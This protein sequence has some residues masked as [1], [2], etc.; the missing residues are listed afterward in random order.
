MPCQFFLSYFYWFITLILFSSLLFLG[1]G[2]S[3]SKIYKNLFK[4]NLHNSF[5]I[6]THYH[7]IPRISCPCKWEHL[8]HSWRCYEKARNS[9]S[10]ER[11][12]EAPNCSQILHTLF[13]TP[14]TSINVNF[15]Y[16]NERN[17]RY[18]GSILNC[19]FKITS[20]F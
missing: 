15:W 8:R 13:L 12:L 5:H 9:W 7:D 2:R 17:L 3:V 14:Y 10:Y 20:L 11:S 18:K 19:L 1:N 4:A 16:L 6:I